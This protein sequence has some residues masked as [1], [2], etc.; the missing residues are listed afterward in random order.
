MVKMISFIQ[1]YLDLYIFKHNSVAILIMYYLTMNFGLVS[2]T[3][4]ILPHYDIEDL[5]ILN[6]VKF[7]VL[8]IMLEF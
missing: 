4:E 3:V 7:G 5:I 8:I 1:K 2:V 6:K